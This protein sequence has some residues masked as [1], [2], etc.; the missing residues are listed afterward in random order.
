MN[1]HKFISLTCPTCG[2]KLEITESIERF[3]CAHCENEHIVK[4]GGGIDSITHIV[5][6]LSSENGK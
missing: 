3:A 4:R 2:G 6:E 1:N 5:E